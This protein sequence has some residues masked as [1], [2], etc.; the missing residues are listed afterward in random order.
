[1]SLKDNFDSK[2]FLRI[3]SQLRTIFLLTNFNL[4]IKRKI[5]KN[6][7]IKRELTQSEFLH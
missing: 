7:F 2:T 4:E 3:F 1:M 5:V 6:A